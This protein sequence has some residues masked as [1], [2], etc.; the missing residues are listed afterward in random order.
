[1]YSPMEID[2]Q[3]YYIKPMN[4]PFHI[5]IYNDKGHSYRDLPLRW[6]ELGTVY[7]YERS[8]VLHGLTRVRGFTQDDAHI[9]CTP[10]QM[11]SEILE[12][13]RFSLNIW[14]TFGFSEIKAYLATKPQESVGEQSKWDAALESLRKA[15]EAEGL[16]YEIDEGGG[17]FYGP[18]IDLKI[19]DAIGREWQ[20]TT[21][22]FDFNEPE[23]FNMTFVDSDSQHKRPYMIH[24]ALL[25]SL[26]RFFG[27]LI[28]HFGGAFPVWISPEQIAVIPVAEQFNEY[29]KKAAAQIKARDLRVTAEL[30]DD[31][32]NAKIRD[33][34]TRKIPYMLVVG[35]REA[36]DGTVSSRLRDGRQLPAMKI[37]EFT[38]YALE[39]IKSRSL[40]L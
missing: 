30:S 26:E 4:C 37:D 5:L 2:K 8:G 40:E 34:Q 23:R 35:Q 28:E 39:K 12:V 33:C 20:M 16:A 14:K 6:A 25:G 15:I 13:L 32:L 7:R 27:I 22:Q 31:R 11:E 9:I 21:I 10:E 29:A 1:M 38:E 36:D 17:A 3:D 18:K 24:R 19:K